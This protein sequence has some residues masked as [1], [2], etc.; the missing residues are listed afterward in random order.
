[1]RGIDRLVAVERS[2][3]PMAEALPDL[4][5]P[6]TI[7]V[8]LIRICMAGLGQY[9]EPTFRAIGLSES[10]FHVLCLLMAS[11]RGRASPSELSELVGTSRA[12]MTRILG[13]LVSDG[14]ATRSVEERDSRRHMI[15]ITTAGVR[16]ANKAVPQLAAPLKQ[17][18]SGLTSAEFVQFDALLRKTI[19]S[20][21]N[22]T[23]PF[24]ARSLET[25]R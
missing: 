21:D 7:M 1:M 6:E 4:P 19:V 14:L 5:M 9:F 18:F 17:A 2:S 16:A 22:N 10:A 11:S 13:S 8:R 3:P 23:V 15:Q 24:R 25:G 12:N 20:F